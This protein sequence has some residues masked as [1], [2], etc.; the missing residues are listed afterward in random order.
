M[1]KRPE[2]ERIKSVK[3]FGVIVKE[4]RHQTWGGRRTCK[5]TL[6]ELAKAAGV[7]KQFL[8]DLEKGKGAKRFAK[9]LRIAEALGFEFRV[10]GSTH[11]TVN[12]FTRA[13]KALAVI[14]HP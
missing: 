14:N 10:T 11:A 3:D 6:E 4:A 9:A 13:L 12:R 5:T 8:V 2:T 1:A 7:S